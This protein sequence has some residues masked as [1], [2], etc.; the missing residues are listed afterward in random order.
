MNQE[1]AAINN[2]ALHVHQLY[3]HSSGMGVKM[4]AVALTAA[5]GRSFKSARKFV[6]LKKKTDS[7]FPTD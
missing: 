2:V 3:S 6:F 1:T 5:S 7:A 4:P